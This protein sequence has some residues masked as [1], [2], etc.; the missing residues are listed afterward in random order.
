MKLLLT[1][2][3][4]TSPKA[5]LILTQLL[6]EVGIGLMLG[7]IHAEKPSAKHN[8]RLQFHHSEVQGF[9]MV[10]LWD[11]FKDYCNAG[12]FGA[13]FKDTRPN[14][15]KTYF[16]V[17]FNTLSIPCFNI[18]RELFYNSSGVK[19]IPSNL[20]EYFTA[21]SLAYWFMDD[22][23]KALSGYYFCTE[24]FSENDINILLALLRTKYSLTC[25]AHKTTNGLRIYIHKESIEQFNKLIGPF[26]LEEFR[27]KLHA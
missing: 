13:S 10:H 17:R 14:R 6:L 8:T 25:S 27:Y 5:H 12:P 18:F 11:L 20:G 7:D 21:C 24:S 2:F 3:Y 1:R 9:Y 22:G 16:S 23:Y 4:R 26:I 15:M 19:F